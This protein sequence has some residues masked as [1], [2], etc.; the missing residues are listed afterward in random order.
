MCPTTEVVKQKNK[1]TAATLLGGGEEEAVEV[2]RRR[3]GEELVLGSTVVEVGSVT[4]VEDFEALVGRGQAL[5]TVGGQLEGV[6][7]RLLAT[8]F[9]A[10]MDAKVL[11]LH[12]NLNLHLLLHLLLHL[13]LHTHLHLY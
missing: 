3:S 9:G 5:D 7:G 10:D 13:H 4:P 6:V 12:L 2:K 11:H 8:A 1:R